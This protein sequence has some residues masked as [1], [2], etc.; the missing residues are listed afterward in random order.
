MKLTELPIIKQVVRF[1]GDDRVLDTLILLGPV[2][3]ALIAFVGRT[4]ITT[5][6]AATYVISLPAYVLYRSRST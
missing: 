1:G 2:L 3:I 5:V 4:P 6:L